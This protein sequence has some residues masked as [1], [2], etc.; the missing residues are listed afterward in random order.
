MT[1]DQSQELMELGRFFTIS[2]SQFD[3][4]QPVPEMFSAAIDTE[5]HRLLDDPAYADFCTQN[6]GRLIN[7]VENTGYGRIS[8]ITAYEEQFGPLPKIW[9]TDA[10]GAVDEEALARYREAG[11]VWAEWDCKPVPGDGD[12]VA[13]KTRKVIAR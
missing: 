6:A 12:D 9:F 4:G 8:W 7:H 13:P 5:W 1:T 11:E 2:A 3:A 10:D